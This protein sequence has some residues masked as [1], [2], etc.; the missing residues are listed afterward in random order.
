MAIS[1]LQ[2]ALIGVGAIAV[3]GVWAY[4][5]WQERKHR[6]LAERI[7][8]GGEQTDVLLDSADVPAGVGATGGDAAIEPMQRVEPAF[9][10]ATAVEPVAAGAPDSPWADP[11]ADGIGRLEF[12]EAV[13]APALW[14]AQAEW[15]G[16]LAKPLYW[17]AQ[18]D[19]EWRLLT[20]HDAGRYSVFLAAQQLADRRGAVSETE[21]TVFAEGVR[22]LAAQ[23]G[24]V[25][26]VPEVGT[27]LEQARALDE[28]CAGVDVQLSINIADPGGTAFAGTKLRGLAEAAGMQLED[29][30]R[31]HACDEQGE[32]LY[33][34]GNLGVELFE[35]ESLG[36]LATHGITLTLDVPNVGQGAHVF[37]RMVATARQFAQG[38]G[39]VLVDA[40]RAPLTDAMIAGIRAKIEEIQVRMEARQIVAGSARARRLFS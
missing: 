5:K 34:L 1:E 22:H 16:H 29:D 15:A 12:V 4:N 25:A 23:L 10:S 40:Q 28:F 30:G 33:T 13:A 21:L 7:L 8:R 14:A 3:A 38:L 37:D 36:S 24:G 2:L 39:G 17:V 6:Q 31:Y 26:T 32:T 20:A 35:A 27:M 11:V 9:S 19:G 18:V